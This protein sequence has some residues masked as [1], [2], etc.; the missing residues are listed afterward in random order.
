MT[1]EDSPK[2]CACPNAV[3]PKGEEGPV[4][5]I[6]R[7]GYENRLLILATM[8]KNGLKKLPRL[9]KSVQG[10]VSGAVILDTGS[11]DGTVD[12]LEGKNKDLDLPSFPLE[13]V[14]EP[15]VNFEISRNRLNELAA[16]KG[17]WL[18]LLDDDMALDFQMDKKALRD[19]IFASPKSVSGYMV[20]HAGVLSY[21]N[22]RIVRGGTPL[23][24]KGVTHEYLQILPPP[25]Q[26]TGVLVEHFYN[27]GPEK[28]VR[29]LQLLSADIARDP[30]D[31]RTIFY[32]ANTLRDM[33]KTPA[34]IRFY[35]MRAKMGGWDEEI[36]IS[37]FEASRL[38][39][40]AD[41]MKKTYEFRPTR[42]EAAAWLA[43]YYESQD[44][45]AQAVEWEDKRASI[46]IPEDTLFV[47]LN[48]YGKNNLICPKS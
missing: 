46:A 4:G 42:A 33:N 28:F 17:D 16:P 22:P 2:G 38:A 44:C 11:T 3:G 30:D 27:H 35:L 43:K 1:T 29:D 9:F 19:I 25:K 37:M 39:R 41:W 20:K 14:S 13:V 15:F 18:L 10:F 6:C 47:N 23:K 32:L 21:W 36:Y 8:T 45:I 48:C 40:N 7:G 26:L 5:H 12:W 24:Y 34:A 31:P